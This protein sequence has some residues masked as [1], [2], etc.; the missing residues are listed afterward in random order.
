[1]NNAEIIYSWLKSH[2][3]C[4]RI[5]LSH[6]IYIIYL[7]HTSTY[8]LELDSEDDGQFN[9]KPGNCTGIPLTLRRSAICDVLQLN[10]SNQPELSLFFNQI[11]CN[12][13]TGPWGSPSLFTRDTRIWC[14]CLAGWW[15]REIYKKYSPVPQSFT[16]CN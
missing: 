11:A 8:Y 13:K 2:L 14:W 1:M 9:N 12:K 3:N 4:L 15:C 7:V 16:T 5:F 10:H 6:L